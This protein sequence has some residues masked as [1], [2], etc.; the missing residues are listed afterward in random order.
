MAVPVLGEA[1]QSIR[2]P[3]IPNHDNHLSYFLAS[4]FLPL[5]LG[6]KHC[7]YP[8]APGGATLGSVRRNWQCEAP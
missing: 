4:S 7:L 3:K 5:T 1:Y 6:A 8:D 2:C